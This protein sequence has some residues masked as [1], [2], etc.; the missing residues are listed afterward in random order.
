ENGS[1]F[2]PERDLPAPIAC[3]TRQIWDAPAHAPVR[4]RHVTAVAHDV[5]DLAA[6]KQVPQDIQFGFLSWRLVAPSGLA[7]YERVTHENRMHEIGVA[8]YRM[9]EDCL[10]VLDPLA[11]VGDQPERADVVEKPPGIVDSPQVAV[12][13]Q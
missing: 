6:R 13:A 8:A 11:P 4:K 2:V 7:L 1:H 9:G 12:F 5:N 3:G 10:R